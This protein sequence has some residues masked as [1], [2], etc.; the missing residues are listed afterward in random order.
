MP[1]FDLFGFKF[2]FFSN[3]FK[4]D[5]ELEPVHIH[6]TDGSVLEKNSPKWWVGLNK[7]KRDDDQDLRHYGLKTSDLKKIEEIIKNNSST[8]IEMWADF[9]KGY[10]IEIHNDVK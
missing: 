7:C 8:I 4:A 1:S 6:V 9:F 3:E 10:D 2:F 5:G